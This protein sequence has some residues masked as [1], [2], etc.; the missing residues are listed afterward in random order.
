MA[1]GIASRRQLA[2]E[3][4]AVDAGIDVFQPRSLKSPDSR[5]ALQAIRPDLLVTAAY[6][7]LLPRAVLDLPAHGC[8]NLHASLLPRWRG[9]S[10]IN[11]AILAGDEQTGISLMQMDEGL[12]TGPVIMEAATAILDEETAGELHDRLAPLAADLLTDAL[13]RLESGCL[14]E[15]RPQDDALATHAPLIN[16][17]DARLDWHLPAAELARRVRG[18]HPWPVAFAELDGV[19][20]RIHRARAVPGQGGAPGTLV[21]GGGQDAVVVACGEGML[22]IL[23][24]QAP[25]RKRV[26]ARDWLNAHP[27]WR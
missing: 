2:L 13:D 7:L 16:K 19:D 1:E 24:L 23:E 8:W 20:F 4:F 5:S 25:G 14:P 3:S 17:A 27:D 21:R 18:Y 12:D 26:S 22:E 15:P 9:A 10:P 6:G 11:Q